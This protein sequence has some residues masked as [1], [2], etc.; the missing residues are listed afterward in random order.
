MSDIP[1]GYRKIEAYTNGREIVATEWP[2]SDDEN[3]DCD[4]L[5]C[6]TLWHVKYRVVCRKGKP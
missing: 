3:H 6:S 1:K 2:T 4:A 5:G